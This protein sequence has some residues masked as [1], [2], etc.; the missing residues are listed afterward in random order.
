[1]YIV[2]TIST[3]LAGEL[4]HWYPHQNVSIVH[5]DKYI[6]NDAYPAKFRQHATQRV[7]DLGV[8]LILED[9]ATMPSDNAYTSV[10]TNKGTAI[11]ADLVVCPA[12]YLHLCIS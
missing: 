3:E 9:R 10:T 6:L 2:L 12:C 5:S 7:H 11:K 8:N 4:K 1:M